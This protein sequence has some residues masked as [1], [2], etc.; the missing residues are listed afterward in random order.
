MPPPWVFRPKQTIVYK[1]KCRPSIDSDFVRVIQGE[2]L[3]IQ[4]QSNGA[5]NMVNRNAQKKCGM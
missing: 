3:E 4:Q 5:Y 1:E 2:T